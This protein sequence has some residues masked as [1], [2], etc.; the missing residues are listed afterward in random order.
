ML[1]T[2]FDK[3][4]DAT[5]I[6]SQCCAVPYSPDGQIYHNCTVNPNV[7]NQF[8]C[9]HGNRQWVTC[10]HPAGAFI[11]MQFVWLNSKIT[12]K[13]CSNHFSSAVTLCRQSVFSS[14]IQPINFALFVE[15]ATSYALSLCQPHSVHFS[16]GSP[17]PAQ[18]PSLLSLSITHYGSH[19]GTCFDY[20][21]SAILSTVEKN[22]YAPD[23]N[24]LSAL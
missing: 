8:G 20:S 2:Y 16:P 10:Q 19:S 12:D 9:Y 11:S 14:L 5:S 17:H 15:L 4:D 24:P 13:N 22:C 7:S 18:I 1:F 3:G 23:L 21:Q 6:P